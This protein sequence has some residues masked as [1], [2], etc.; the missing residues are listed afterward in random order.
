MNV[1]LIFYTPRI[2]GYDHLIYTELQ[3]LFFLYLIQ[4]CKLLEIEIER[5]LN[6]KR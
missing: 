4:L 3:F 2:R 1:L 5:E 6:I